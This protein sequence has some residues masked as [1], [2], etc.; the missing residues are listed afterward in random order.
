[1]VTAMTPLERL[2]AQRL[3]EWA[4]KLT[5]PVRTGEH[6]QSAFAFGLA[7]DW[8]RAT[9]DD[10]T[11]AVIEARARALYG[12]DRGCN[13]AFEPSGQDF[14]SPCLAAADLLR[15]V[16]PAAEFAAWLGAALPR[17]TEDD[18]GVVPVVPADR[19]DG[20]LAH[21]DGL[22]LSRAWMLEGIAT[23]LPEDDARRGALLRAADAHATAGI[24][25][26]D[27]AHYEG[28]HW[29]GTF[30]VYLVT[31]RGIGN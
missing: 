3:V 15:R 9:G 20:K 31:R 5:H 24:A 29:L 10:A 18:A 23:G 11:A 16:M 4:G 17:I 19:S 27:G 1:M 2:A 14:L 8:A 28:A 30:A 22:N 26:T 12:G 7:L 13:L 21:L 6:S 25:A